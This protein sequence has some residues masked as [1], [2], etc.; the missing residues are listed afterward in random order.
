MNQDTVSKRAV[1]AQLHFLQIVQHAVKILL[2]VQL[3]HQV[4]VC[5][6]MAHVLQFNQLDV[7]SAAHHNI[8]FVKHAQLDSVSKTEAHAHKLSQKIAKLV[9]QLLRLALLVKVQIASKL[10]VL[11]QQLYQL[12]VVYAVKLH[13]LVHLA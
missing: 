6:K 7:H 10:V 11:V 3:V 4:F 2:F 9:V 8:M 5:N 1:L 13:K 12:I